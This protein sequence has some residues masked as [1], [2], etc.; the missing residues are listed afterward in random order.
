MDASNVL[1]TTQSTCCTGEN[2]ANVRFVL[3]SFGDMHLVYQQPH[4]AGPGLKGHYVHKDG[5]CEEWLTTEEADIVQRFDPCSASDT[6][7]FFIA[8]FCKSVSTH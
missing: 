2:E 1:L 4:L 5:C 8:K 6:I 3:K 7:G